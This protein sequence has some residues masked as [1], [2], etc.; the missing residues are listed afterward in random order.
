MRAMLPLNSPRWRELHGVAAEDVRQVVAAVESA[1]A[2]GAGAAPDGGDGW[3]KAWEGLALDLM[4]E[5]VVVDG[6]YAAL[7]HVVA[8]AAGPAPERFAELWVDAGLMVTA[9]GRSPVPADLRAGFDAA[10]REAE[11]AAVRGFLAAATPAALCAQLALSCL[12]F[13]GHHT[14]EVLWR[15]LDPEETHLVLCCPGCGADAEFPGFFA[16]G[17]CPPFDAPP[18]AADRVRAG[19]HPWGEVADALREDALGPGWEPFLRVAREV[20]AAGVPRGTPGQAVLCLVAGMVAVRGTPGWAGAQWAR[21]LMLL[22]GDFRCPDCERTWTTADGLVED[23]DGA[24]PQDHGRRTRP[25]A[26]GAPADGD[27]PAQPTS[28]GRTGFRRDGHRLLAADGTPVGHVESFARPRPD[29]YR[30]VDAVA[31]VAGPGL[32]TLV[33]GAGDGGLCLWDLADGSVRHGPLPGHPDRVRSLTALPQADGAVLLASGGEGGTLGVRDA[34]TGRPVLEP[35]GNWLGEVTG[36]CAAALPDGRRLLVT[37]TSRGAVRLRDPLTGEPLA[38]LNPRGRSIRSIAAVPIAV[39]HTLVAAA[40]AQGDVHLWDPA[41]DDPWDRGAAVPPDERALRDRRHRVALVAAVS[42]H[43]RALLATAD[44]AGAVLLWDPATGGPVG[45]GLPPER[46]GSP[47]TAVAAL[48]LPDRPGVVVT[49]S[50]PG[51]SLRIWEPETGAVRHVDLDVAVTCLAVAGSGD[52]AEVLVGHD[53]GVLR[54]PA[55]PRTSP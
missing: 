35:V 20:A 48:V 9:A 34:A 16:D 46:S 49:G 43:G 1:S 23:P 24:R 47:L 5:D 11:A 13:A 28:G 3:R 29:A 22:T 15:F 41:V 7:P 33:A 30:G 26:E 25:P 31:V 42:V 53:R 10:L 21:R 19:G 54:L 40:D 27:R 37:A 39:D 4:C 55:Y 45:D 17:P 50:G 44:P 2:T 6:A 18:P 51:R 36:T 12:A 52:G 38:R 8:A 14:A 32:P